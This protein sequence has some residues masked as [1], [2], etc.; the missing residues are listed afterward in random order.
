LF[1][2]VSPRIACPFARKRRRLARVEAEA[3]VD[4][5][6]RRSTS[7]GIA[8][9]TS[10]IAA[11]ATNALV[12]MDVSSREY[13]ARFLFNRQACSSPAPPSWRLKKRLEPARALSK[14]KVDR[15]DRFPPPTLLQPQ[16]QRAACFV[17]GPRRGWPHGL[18]GS[19]RRDR[20]TSGT[21]GA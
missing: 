4:H 21:T 10:A 1:S 14:M 19:A 8:T 2:S 5:F 11:P 20:P 7:N 18:S 6:I 3:P 17:D 13:R 12:G 16:R 9:P 15:H